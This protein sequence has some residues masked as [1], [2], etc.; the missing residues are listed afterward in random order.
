MWKKISL[1]LLAVVVLILVVLVALFIK[2]DLTK[3]DLKE[4][5]QPPSQFITLP[6]G[7]VAHY[8]MKVTRMALCWC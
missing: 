8:R 6:S 1:G 7:A 2:P 3:D 4:Y 5:W